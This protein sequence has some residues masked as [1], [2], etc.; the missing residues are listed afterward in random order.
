MPSSKGRLVEVLGIA[1]AGVVILVISLA[2]V[3]RADW[4][5][6]NIAKFLLERPTSSR[7]TQN[8]QRTT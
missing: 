8:G 1:R 6:V 4:R 2:K 5:K 7:K 3:A